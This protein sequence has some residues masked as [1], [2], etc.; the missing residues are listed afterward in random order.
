MTQ[1]DDEAGPLLPYLGPAYHP[2]GACGAYVINCYHYAPPA[3]REA[4]AEAKR[5][6]EAYTREGKE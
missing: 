1:P 6:S 4:R 5:R 2:C 3:I